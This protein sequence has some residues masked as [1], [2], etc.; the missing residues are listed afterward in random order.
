[1]TTGSCLCGAIT[2]QA[3]GPLRPVIA[4]HCTQ[5]RKSSGHHVAA[6]SVRRDRIRV[7]GE[8]TWYA[9]SPEAKRG[10]CGTC[11][12]QM[13]WDGPGENLSIFAGCLDSHPPLEIGGHIF[14]DD[15]GDYYQID[16][17][18]PQSGGYDA[19]LTTQVAPK[20]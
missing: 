16:P 11:G 10:F 5:C 14:T 12:S 17:D 1:M 3:S 19:T 13:F 2:F 7:T 9:S 4:C 8:V 15:K 18:A 6:T 20:G